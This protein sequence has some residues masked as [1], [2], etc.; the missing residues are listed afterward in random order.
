MSDWRPKAPGIASLRTLFSPAT[1]RRKL[2]FRREEVP[3]LPV[4]LWSKALVMRKKHLTY[5]EYFRADVVNVFAF[6]EDYEA[7][8]HA[9]ISM[10]LHGGPAEADVALLHPMSEIKSLRIRKPT[11]RF[12]NVGA[13]VGVSSI[14]FKPLA[15]ADALSYF[16]TLAEEE[17]PRFLL[18]HPDQDADLSRDWSERDCVGL[19]SS[20]DGLLLLASSLLRYAREGQMERELDLRPPPPHYNYLLGAGSAIVRF[21]LPGSIAWESDYGGG[22]DG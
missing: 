8:S 21:W 18:C 14:D 19:E 5:D 3:K 20:Q 15:G 9:L 13:V 12:E 11:Q 4:R 7:L 6:P 16:G 2:S 1:A 10:L 22:D 17:K